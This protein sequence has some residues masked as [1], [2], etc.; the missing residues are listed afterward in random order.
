MLK[1][2]SLFLLLLI[3]APLAL[4][5]G[6]VSS[7][8]VKQTVYW[9]GYSGAASTTN[10]S[11]VLT[12]SRIDSFVTTPTISTDGS[13]YFASLFYYNTLAG[14]QKITKTPNGSALTSASL[15][16]LPSG[17]PSANSY[18][19]TILK[20]ASNALFSFDRAGNE[21]TSG[22]ITAKSILTSGGI[23]ASGGFT[24]DLTGNA[25]GS[26]G[27]VTSIG[28]H[29]STELSDTS[30]IAY[31]NASNTFTGTTQTMVS[32]KTTSVTIS[33]NTPTTAGYVWTAKKT[34]GEGYW[35][36]AA[37]GGGSWG[38]ITGTLSDQ[39]DLQAA[40]DAK[41]PLDTE[42]TA[43]AGLT[44]A[45]DKGIYFTGS[46]TAGT[47]DLTSAGRAL[48]DDAAASN[49]RTT[50]GVGAGDSP[51]FTGLT[52]SGLT[53]GSVPF[54]G[55]SG[56]ISQDNNNLYFDDTNDQ[57]KVGIGSTTTSDLATIV[58][59]GDQSNSNVGIFDNGSAVSTILHRSART[60]GA[61]G[62]QYL[63]QRSRGSRGTPAILNS[64]DQL[65]QIGG[66]G[67][68]GS[69]YRTGVQILGIVDATPGSSDMPGRLEIYTTPDGSA[70][71]ARRFVVGQ[72]GAVFIGDAAT[73]T[74]PINGA[75]DLQVEDALLVKGAI[76][77]SAQTASRVAVFDSSKNIVSGGAALATE[78]KCFTF[79]G[80][81][82]VQANQEVTI[83]LPY[84][85]T[86]TEATMEGDGLTGSAV[87]DVWVDS[88]ANF[89][90]TVADTITASAKPTI[91]SSTKSQDT[92]L[93]GWTTSI[94]AGRFI[95]AHVD[96]SSTFQV[97]RLY[98]T[99]TKS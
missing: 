60:A 20:D 28:S 52:L 91:S 30:N 7:Q 82:T 42:L 16:I 12:R 8:D 21:V 62:P 43:L 29:A 40:L 71:P 37:G 83:Y 94:A 85:A 96:S 56:V 68:D 84:A 59:F 50:L 95:V 26:A 27:T 55:T 47:Y 3:G 64:S 88:Y 10:T 15:I 99:L 51:T 81:P 78:V 73:V 4:A 69:A 11:T 76:N 23:T 9:D 79:V 19:M 31:K 25:S 58:A 77:M 36:A 35:A 24:G 97:L 75:G 66:Q 57:L 67:Y 98:L 53:I 13:G 2:L 46:G 41:Q 38:S 44:S 86:I 45:A 74:S 32:I 49:Q 34:N 92:T 6:T 70:T 39:T 1:L 14:T 5:K 87:V 33:G 48:L 90:P 65:L 54:A 17:T 72:Q 22:S 63:Q 61:G 80:N 18:Y 93:T 89:R